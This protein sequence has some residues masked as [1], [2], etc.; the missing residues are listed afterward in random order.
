MCQPL[1]WSTFHLILI[2]VSIVP[3]PLFPLPKP[4][5]TVSPASLSEPVLV[6]GSLVGLLFHILRASFPELGTKSPW[7]LAGR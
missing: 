4:G 2:W 3:E 5:S 7:N 6:H 1:P